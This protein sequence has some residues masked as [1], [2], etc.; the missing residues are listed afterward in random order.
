MQVSETCTVERSGPPLAIRCGPVPSFDRADLD[1]VRRAFRSAVS[2]SF[3]QAWL[4]AA[5]SGFAPAVVRLGWRGSSLLVFAELTDLDIYN[6]ATRPNQRTWE[7]GDVFEMFFKSAG[8][9]RYVE[10][11]VTPGNQRLQL[12][13]PDTAAAARAQATGE[14]GGFLIRDDAFFSHT[15][16]DSE[17][18]GWQVFAEIPALAV[19]GSP[20]SI[21]NMKWQC[22][23]GRY[24]YTR[25]VRQPVISSTSPHALPDFHRQHEWG[26]L[27]FKT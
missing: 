13:F 18:N 14:F 25:G 9:D 20:A 11:H 19:C 23:F 5:E 12:G 1:S 6:A 4:P 3:R 24:D 7:L 8:Q 27:I 15:W 2:C 10:F 22:S 17:R 21:E 26:D 16:T